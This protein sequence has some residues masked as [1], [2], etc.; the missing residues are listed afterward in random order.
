MR[1]CVFIP[2]IQ[3][4]EIKSPDNDGAVIGETNLCNTLFCYYGVTLIGLAPVML[5][6]RVL[7]CI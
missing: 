3:S 1:L 4:L 2:D 5:A 6:Y 7:G